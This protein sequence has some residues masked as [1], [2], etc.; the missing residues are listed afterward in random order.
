M[1]YGSKGCGWRAV[2]YAGVMR[3]PD[4]GGLTGAE[5]ARRE[6]VR[7]AAAELIEAGDGRHL[8]HRARGQGRPPRPL[9]R[10]A[11]CQPLGAWLANTAES[12]AM[13]LRPGNA[14]SGTDAD[15][16]R[17]LGA[18]LAQVPAGWRRR[19]LI[20]VDGAGASHELIGHLLSLATP[21]KMVLFT[22]G[23]MITPA[24]A[25]EDAIGKLP[26]SAWQ[27][28]LDQDGNVQEDKHVAEITHLTSRTGG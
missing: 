10:K 1:I 24:A 12:L 17:V 2:Q 4:G 15:H 16:R 7:L 3:Y 21:R 9:T 20:R 18:A 27:P 8:G 13:L 19:L 5:R 6:Q 14:G 26:A 28:G 25:D 11:A 23:W 22:C